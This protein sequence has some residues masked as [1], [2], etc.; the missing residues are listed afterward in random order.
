MTE[1]ICLTH[2]PMKYR[3]A[4]DWWECPGFDGEGCNVH[5]V[6][7]EDVQLGPDSN[8]PGVR[9]ST[10]GLYFSSE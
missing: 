7:Q 6:Y 2:G 9:V 5:L 3:F 1:V 10:G 4:L 8:I